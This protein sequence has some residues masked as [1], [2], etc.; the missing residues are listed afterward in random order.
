MYAKIL[1]LNDWHWRD[2]DF[3]SIRGYTDATTATFKDVVAYMKNNGVTHLILGGDTIDKGYRSAFATFEHTM[4]M[5]EMNECVNGEVYNCIGNHLFLERDNNPEMYWIQPSDLA[6]PKRKLHVTRQLMKTVPFLCLGNTQIS[7]FHYTKEH[8]AYVQEL[9]PG[10]RNH[11]GI[12]HDSNVVPS[13]VLKNVYPDMKHNTTAEYL[14]HIYRNVD[15]AI[16]AHIHKPLGRFQVDT[17]SRTLTV[18]CPGSMAVTKFSPVEIHEFVE[19][20]IIEIDDT[21]MSLSSARFDLHIELLEFVGQK[22]MT[23]SIFETEKT[24]FSGGASLY[25]INMAQYLLQKGATGPAVEAAELA[26]R[27]ALGINEVVQLAHKGV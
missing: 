15:V 10:M 17:L 8:K 26:S 23:A 24:Q 18:W 6:K 25:H 14:D 9:Q 21:G 7:F 16:V 13:T 5:L 2:T 12:Y 27:G 19:A 20:P 3:K 11:I 1:V 22:D 4:M